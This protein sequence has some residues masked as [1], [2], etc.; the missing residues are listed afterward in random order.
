MTTSVTTLPALDHSPASARRIVRECLTEA[1]LE[2]IL[3]DALI[4]VSELVTNAF[5]HAGT[6]VQLHLRFWP[7]QPPSS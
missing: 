6:A 7:R 2:V 4:L 3:D 5:V 1:G